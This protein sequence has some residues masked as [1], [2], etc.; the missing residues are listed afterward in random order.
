MANENFS[1]QQQRLIRTFMHE[2]NK[3]FDTSMRKIVEDYKEL[4]T[5]TKA[6]SNSKAK[7]AKK[8]KK[9][10][11][12]NT[13]S[14]K[15]NTNA[16]TE[17]TEKSEENSEAVDEN[18]T[19]LD[20]NTT[21]TDEN[22]TATEEESESKKKL[23][24]IIDQSKQSFNQ[25]AGSF[26]SN[27]G[28][29]AGLTK[30]MSD[31]RNSLKYGTSYD[32][33]D[34]TMMG[35]DAEDL[36]A[37]KTTY[38]QAALAATNGTEGFIERLQPLQRE[39]VMY[40]GS[41]K[42]AAYAAAGITEISQSIGV[43]YGELSNSII[44]DL[45]DSFKQM[46][47]QIGMTGEEFAKMNKTLIEDTDVREQLMRMN[48][49]QRKQH[50]LNMNQQIASFQKMG[51]TADAAMDMAKR[52]NKVGTD[53]PMERMKKA[54]KIQALSGAYG[55][56]SEGAEIARIMRKGGR[57]TQDEKLRMKSLMGTVS[58]TV[59]DS[60]GQSLSAEMFGSRMLEQTGLKEDV[61]AYNTELL[62][63]LRDI[64]GSAASREE[65]VRTDVYAPLLE[66]SIQMLDVVKAGFT[67]VIGLLG[68]AALLKGKGMADILLPD[69]FGGDDT[70]KNGKKTKTGKAARGKG[71]KIKG[72]ASAIKGLFSLSTNVEKST[73][74][75]GKLSKL[76]AAKNIAAIGGAGVAGIAGFGIDQGLNNVE[77]TDKTTQRLKQAG[78][79]VGDALSGAG[80]GGTLGLLLGP[81]GAFVGAIGGAIVGL[82]KGIW[83]VANTSEEELHS[84]RMSAFDDEVAR[85]RASF[86]D[87]AGAN[88]Q[89]ATEIRSFSEN[90]G[91]ASQ[92]VVDVDRINDMKEVSKELKSWS[93]KFAF[94]DRDMSDIREKT[95]WS[96]QQL[97]SELF[98]AQSYGM[99][100]QTDAKGNI[101]A[102]QF[103]K[104][105]DQQLLWERI[106]RDM[107]KNKEFEGSEGRELI[108]K[109]QKVYAD[110]LAEK[111]KAEKQDAEKTQAKLQEQY[112]K[113]EKLLEV[114]TKPDSNES[115]K[116]V[117]GLRDLL[118]A[119]RS[120]L[121]V[122]N[123]TVNEI[124]KVSSNTKPG[125][126]RANMNVN[127]SSKHG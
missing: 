5:Q 122:Q 17:N 30:G 115:P 61:L 28:M 7:Q 8:D 113:F 44:P 31:F 36:V 85:L 39:L 105:S 99:D 38:R 64:D 62:A 52:L 29:W 4:F 48:Q 35:L 96:D 111:I 101:N 3:L 98:K 100:Y 80:I 15:K 20:E 49:E 16:T 86:G 69:M 71:G 9:A 27:V 118:D 67:G 59:T 32:P 12:D 119:I 63:G 124:K 123:D 45:F 6:E 79:I 77:E 54:A 10:N 68:G 66:N 103:E 53:S 94:W 65:K 90:A 56:G 104:D 24:K 84:R 37:I 19:A 81:P 22:T 76:F 91:K 70:D 46:N 107:A 82:T 47:S 25:W 112:N 2:H 23:N 121:D 72:L 89:Y 114:A 50:I 11:D 40:T 74:A 51:Y 93:R 102:G 108:S 120:Q 106:Q 41:M 43:S 57:A 109:L 110:Q 75:T 1:D 55:L 14:V 21:A 87:L 34:A 116:V 117:S 26:L 58:K 13:D 73:N 95:G 127:A 126:N 125:R 78:G 33:I 92:D 42:D 97:A 60:M 18:T 83:E 88:K